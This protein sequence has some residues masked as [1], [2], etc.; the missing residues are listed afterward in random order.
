MG[1]V[2]VIAAV[3]GFAAFS[4]SPDAP[5]GPAAIAAGELAPAAGELPLS[6]TYTTVDGA[7]RDP[8]VSAATNGL[9]V[10]PIRETP[11][12]D[13]P[14]GRAIARMESATQVGDTWLP[15]I[16]EKSGWVQVLLPSK[17]NGSTGWLRAGD[18]ERARSPYAITVHLESMRLELRRDDKA[19]GQWEIGIGKESAP[20][21]AGRTFLLGAF[22]DAEQTYSP[23]ILPLGAH[24]PTLDTFGGGPGTVAIHTWP[25]D[26]VYGTATSDGCIRVPADALDQL[27][28]VPL[29][30][31]VMI[32]ED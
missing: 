15:V 8:A 12:H 3:I 31:L 9:V 22:S 1:V 4:G 5:R 16:A 7:P 30:T 24:S 17:P 2:V 13:A 11:V 26:D 19:V 23:V 10:H 21:P 25:T 6:N 28:E 14:D 18:V 32:N 20:T 29:G 27:S